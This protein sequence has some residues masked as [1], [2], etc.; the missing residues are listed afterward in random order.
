MTHLYALCII[1]SS[2][3][4]FVGIYVGASPNKMLIRSQLRR[5]EIRGYRRAKSMF[6]EDRKW[7]LSRIQRQDEALRRINAGASDD[8]Q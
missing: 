1:A 4:F 2:V 3:M 6:Y 7:Y 8:G 5:A